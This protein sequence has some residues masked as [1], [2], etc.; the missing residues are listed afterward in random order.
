M[1]S[2]GPLAPGFLFAGHML[3]T[4]L[5]GGSLYQ[6]ETCHLAFRW[7]RPS[8]ETLDA[9]YQ[10]G[11][12]PAWQY[13][14]E[15]RTDWRVTHRWLQQTHPEGGAILDVGCFDGAFLNTLDATWTR[16][17]VEMSEA[18]VARA[19]ARDVV[20]LT[21]DAAALPDLDHRFDAVVAFDVI[22]HVRDPFR[23]LRDM[24]DRT[25][26][27]GII[28][29]GTGNTQAWTWRLMGS[30]YWYCTIPEHLSFLNDSWCHHAAQRLDLEV[31]EI[32]HFSHAQ[33]PSLLQTGYEVA[34]NVLYRAFPGLFARLRQWGIGDKDT[35]QHAELKHFPP[36][37]I[38]ARDHLIAVFRRP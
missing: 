12:T 10:Q 17:G 3:D 29:I 38:T 11:D 25:C 13:V 32:R 26:P 15:H 33:N 6:C 30:R 34:A 35:T 22:E 21:T 28:I 31:L 36:Q 18:A 2:I 8:Q 37:W 9:L 4:P 7:P 23:L 20:V 16:Y 27:G 1:R 19:R 24:A 14:P 5:P